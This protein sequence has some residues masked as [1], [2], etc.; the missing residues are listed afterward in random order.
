MFFTWNKENPGLFSLAEKICVNTLRKKTFHFA[1]TSLMAKVYSYL[2]VVRGNESSVA[3]VDSEPS[4]WTRACA[5]LMD[6]GKNTVKWWQREIPPPHHPTTSPAP[7][8]SHPITTSAFERRRAKPQRDV[9][10]E[11]QGNKNQETGEQKKGRSERIKRDELPVKWVGRASTQSLKCNIGKEKEGEKK[12]R[13]QYFRDVATQAT[14][15]DSKHHE[16]IW[17]QGRGKKWKR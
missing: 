14:A 15:N 2:C 5:A 6:V 17:E 12:G 9:R 10:T 13:N 4:A 8:L 11:S 7:T 1:V 16:K 3:E